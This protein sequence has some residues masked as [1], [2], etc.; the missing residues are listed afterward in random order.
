MEQQIAI[1]YTNR[2]LGKLILPLVVEQLLNMTVGLADSLMVASVGEAAVSAVSLVDTVNVL[3]INIFVALATGGAVVAGQ[4]LGRRQLDKANQAAGQLLLFILE[5]SLGV[6]ILL[7]L[8]RGFILHVVFGQITAEVSA[9]ANTYFLIVE[10]STIFLAVY[11]AGAALFR[12]MGNAS[13]S[14]GVSLIMNLI[15]VGGNAILIF[16]F[17]RGVEGVAIP[18]LISRIVAAALMLIL[19]RNPKL[20]LHMERRFSLHHE[21]MII[22]NILRVGV[23]NGIEGGMFQMGKILLL[24]VVSAF[25]T[26][27]VAANAIGGNIA[28][29][30]VLAP[31]SIGLA[32]VTVVSQCVGAGEFDR[33]RMYTRKLMKWSYVSMAIMC[34]LIYLL[35]PW[36]LEL[37]NLSDEATHYARLILL[38]HGGVG[39]LLW[40]LSFALPQALRAAGDTRF[41]MTVSTISMWTFRVVSGVI[42]AK[43]LELGVLGIWYSMS[44]DWSFRSAFFI[45]RYRGHKW[46]EM[47]IE[48]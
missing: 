13:I 25:G 3:I 7:Y 6:T 37:Y 47:G 46:E 44:L 15:N 8:C 18:S 4:Y 26:A 28:N 45:H 10:S 21:K 19:L 23:P 24:S 30:Q 43:Y 40:P 14:M 41:T 48:D 17:H 39:V 35:M 33:A 36:I 11:C 12:V 29:F 2:D 31:L 34:G 32:M 22:R 5:C 16:G 1:Q 42:F 9:Y 38:F 27:S 20:Q